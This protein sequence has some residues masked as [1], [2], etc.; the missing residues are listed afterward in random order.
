MITLCNLL[1][2]LPL[3]LL[4]RLSNVLYLVL[5]YVVRYRRGIVRANLTHA[6]PDKSGAELRELEKTFYRWLCD[7]ALEIVASMRMPVQELRRR[8]KLVNPEVYQKWLEQE[9]SVLFLSAHK[10]NWEWLQYVFA[11]HLPCPMYTVYKPLHDGEFNRLML[12]VRSSFGCQMVAFAD[13]GR[14]MVKGRRRFQAFAMLADQAPGRRDKRHWAPFFGREAPFY[15][16][17]QK[18]AEA[19]QYPVVA[20]D[21]RR[22]K[23]GYYEVHFEVLAEP[24]HHKGDTA[25]LERYIGFMERVIRREP[26]LWLWSHN[27]WKV[28]SKS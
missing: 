8:V 24:P 20:A 7:C 21:M 27:K 17:P 9:Q 5:Y 12:A 26:E 3:A 2:R 16:G 25:I 19:V 13:A 28:R 18:I 15:L 22:V 14:E 10:G 1:S 6:F 4:Y 11:D 23:R